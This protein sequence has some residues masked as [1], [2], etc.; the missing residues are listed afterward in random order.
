LVG[1]IV[2]SLFYSFQSI[3]LVAHTGELSYHLSQMS[4]FEADLNQKRKTL[5]AEAMALDFVMWK[6][7]S[8]QPGNPWVL[9]SEAPAPPYYGGLPNYF[10]QAD[11]GD[12]AKQFEAELVEQI[13]WQGSPPPRRERAGRI[14]TFEELYSDVVKRHV[15]FEVRELAGR[16]QVSERHVR[17]KLAALLKAG[18]I[19]ADWLHDKQWRP[20]VDE[21]ERII[22]AADGK[23]HK[24]HTHA[25]GNG[26]VDFLMQCRRAAEKLKG[27]LADTED[28]LETCRRWVRLAR[29]RPT[30]PMSH[31]EAEKFYAEARE[32]GFAFMRQLAETRRWSFCKLFIGIYAAVHEQAARPVGETIG[33]LGLGHAAF[34]RL[35]TTKEIGDAIKMAE[36]MLASPDWMGYASQTVSE[37]DDDSPPF[38]DWTNKVSVGDLWADTE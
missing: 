10:S 32:R 19:P 20:P 25:I 35:Y 3:H 34:Y 14:E 33:S 17:R 27:E 2:V 29:T 6:A 8:Y 9:S 21:A 30:V 7:K 37:G 18:M 13:Y 22:R 12:Q 4:D 38:S 23:R 36:Q 28:K 11:L 31:D 26:Y 1:F 15:S 5:L 16:L 24:P